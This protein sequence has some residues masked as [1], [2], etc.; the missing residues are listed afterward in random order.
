MSTNSELQNIISEASSF[1]AQAEPERALQVLQPQFEKFGDSPIFLQILGE[2]LLEVS[3]L[4]Q[5]YEVLIR[6]CELDPEVQYG[7]E[8]YLYLGQ[9]IGGA[10]GL[11]YLEVGYNA[12]MNTLSGLSSKS[13]LTGV[14]SA[15]ES[16]DL[17]RRYLVEKTNQAL[18]ASI[19]IWMTDLCMEPEAETQCE[20]LIQK[21]MSLDNESN[22]E[23]WSVLASIRI[24][25]QKDEEARHAI[26]KSWD[27]FR[28]KKERLEQLAEQNSD[29]D[30]NDINQEYINLVQP[31]ITLCKYAIELG[32]LFSA[33]EIASSVQDINEQSVESFHLEGFANY[34][35]ALSVQNQVDPDN[36]KEI[37]QKFDSY[38]IRLGDES[39]SD[40]IYDARV[41]LSGAYKLLQVDSI[42]EETDPELAGQVHDL[43][44]QVGGFLLKP[45]EEQVDETNWEAQIE[46]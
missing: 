12:L 33:I 2:T 9:I 6:A 46:D 3:E 20:E 30:P 25:Q 32:L 11:H 5:A 45:Q 14:L 27:L 39:S 1:N 19:D 44:A 17:A 38:S 37:T 18:F 7:S 16:V 36:S 41:A 10:D 34:L 15:F 26:S 35:C 21:S 40:Y 22:A 42:L 13:D 29:E 43:L 23:S 24:S 28:L 4:E 31:L 8:K